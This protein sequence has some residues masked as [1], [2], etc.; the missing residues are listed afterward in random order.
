MSDKIYP[1]FHM[2][3]KIN[4]YLC[5]NAP[6]LL[7]IKNLVWLHLQ[8]QNSSGILDKLHFSMAWN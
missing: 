2:S 6:L 7:K 1:A 4:I 5:K 3:S 8:K